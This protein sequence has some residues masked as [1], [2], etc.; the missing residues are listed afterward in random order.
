MS[1]TTVIAMSRATGLQLP[2]GFVLPGA[3]VRA[4]TDTRS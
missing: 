2:A 1:R 4:S 3:A